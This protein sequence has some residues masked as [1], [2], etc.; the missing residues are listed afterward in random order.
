MEL[1]IEIGITVKI[2]VAFSAIV[3]VAEWLARLTAV[4]EDPGS[5]HAANSCVYRDSCCDIE[6]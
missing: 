2:N 4:R 3:S 5:N 6:S 1:R